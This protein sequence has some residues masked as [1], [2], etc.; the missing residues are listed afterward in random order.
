M[1][2]ERMSAVALP[3]PVQAPQPATAAG[4]R[5][6]SA[7]SS[8]S[9]SLSCLSWLTSLN[10]SNVAPL[11]PQSSGSWQDSSSDEEG[12]H[13]DD[14]LAI[15]WQSEAG[16]KPPFAYATLIYMALRESDCPKLALA[17]IYDY[18]SDNF[19]YYRHADPGWKVCLSSGAL[20]TGRC[21]PMWK[22]ET[23]DRGWEVSREHYG[24]CADKQTTT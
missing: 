6:D 7:A 21:C 16:R 4:T 22:A 1:M 23:C 5:P 15:D 13:D 3:S 17:E 9:S 19:A 24:P 2:R 14:P 12:V 20:E 8:L 18:I 10:V 11:S